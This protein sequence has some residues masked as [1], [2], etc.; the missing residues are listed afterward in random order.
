M[1]VTP[2][3]LLS[4]ITPQNAWIFKAVRLRALEDSPDAF[5]STYAKECQLTDAD[6]IQRALRWNGEHGAGFLAVAG[7]ACCGIAGSL[8]DQADATRAHLDSMWTAPDAPAARHRA[9]V[10]QRDSWLGL[11]TWSS[12]LA[13]A[14]DVE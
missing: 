3:S 9:F 2:R 10:G 14:G 6:W 11:S 5:G 8:L 4:P 13:T 7:S 12:Y 1:M